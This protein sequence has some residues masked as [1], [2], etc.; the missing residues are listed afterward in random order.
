ML[1][2]AKYDT[3]PML[4]ATYSL[5][6]DAPIYMNTLHSDF[7]TSENSGSNPQ[8]QHDLRA[9]IFPFCWNRMKS[10]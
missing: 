10:C 6:Q 1:C 5:M 4:S 3:T 8:E 9:L 2:I 7:P